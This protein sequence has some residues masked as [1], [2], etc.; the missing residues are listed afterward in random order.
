MKGV[1]YMD[2]LLDKEFNN[3]LNSTDILNK[4]SEISDF[5]DN[6]KTKLS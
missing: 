1:L 4:N 3:C 2:D 5:I 6:I